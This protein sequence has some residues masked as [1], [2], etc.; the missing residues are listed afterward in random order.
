M[1]RQ[2]K[3]EQI[4]Q[5]ETHLQN[6]ERSLATIEKY[7]HDV[8]VFYNYVGENTFSKSEVLKYKA[9]LL[10]KYTATSANSML[11][12]INVFFRF[13]GW[14]DLCVKKP[15]PIFCVI[16]TAF[17]SF[18]VRNRCFRMLLQALFPRSPKL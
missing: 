5:F 15:I 14:Y 17:R 12:A 1:K 4:I 3:Q 9:H 16:F 6:E 11:A 18:R 8:Q 2:L 10:T 13:C 7:L